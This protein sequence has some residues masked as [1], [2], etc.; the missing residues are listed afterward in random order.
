MFL[1][2][3]SR[4]VALICDFVNVSYFYGLDWVTKNVRLGKGH[5][6]L[7]CF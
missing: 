1:K 2:D 4:I 5:G 7:G 3:L 6:F